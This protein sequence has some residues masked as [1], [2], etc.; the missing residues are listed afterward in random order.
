MTPGIFTGVVF[1]WL[2]V[3]GVL[4]GVVYECGFV[5]RGITGFNKVVTVIVD[6]LIFSF[7]GV[8]FF[9]TIYY[10][11]NGIFAFYEVMGFI[12]G[13]FLERLSI[14]KLLAN[15]LFFVYNN[16]VKL[17]KYLKKKSKVFRFLTR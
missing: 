4:F 12:I 16:L 1:L 11:N 14:G 15:I 13:F 5:L 10:V 17:C 3:A 7:A 6:T 8:C 2:V 9:F